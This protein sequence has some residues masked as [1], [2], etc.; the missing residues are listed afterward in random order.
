MDGIPLL[1]IVKLWWR[2][3][4]VGLCLAGRIFE[5]RVGAAWIY[6]HTFCLPLNC[7]SRSPCGVCLPSRRSGLLALRNLCIWPGP[8]YGSVSLIASRAVAL[9]ILALSS[10]LGAVSLLLCKSLM[11]WGVILSEFNKEASLLIAIIWPILFCFQ[12]WIWG[13]CHLVCVCRLGWV[14][15]KGW[16]SR[17]P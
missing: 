12:T 8:S 17:S 16:R 15:L 6:V 10:L 14:V 9:I 7:V 1:P 11:S 3:V 5:L 13:C 2:W 4:V